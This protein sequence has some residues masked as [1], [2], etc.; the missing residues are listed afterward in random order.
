LYP[1]QFGDVAE[2][3]VVRENCM[4]GKGTP[5]GMTGG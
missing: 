3:H 2:L 5:K 4:K 1:M